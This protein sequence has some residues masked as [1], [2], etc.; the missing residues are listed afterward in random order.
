MVFQ[1][2]SCL[3]ALA[4]MTFVS[5]SYSVEFVRKR[6]NEFSCVLFVDKNVRSN[7]PSFLCPFFEW[8]LMPFTFL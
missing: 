5:F 8:Y 7:L 1:T 4:A 2:L 3:I 6:R